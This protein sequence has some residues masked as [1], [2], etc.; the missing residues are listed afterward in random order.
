MSLFTIFLPQRF[1]DDVHRIAVS[2]ER[3]ADQTERIADLLEAAAKP[4]SAENLNPTV[5]EIPRT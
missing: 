5:T 1:I 4:P 2:A 3:Q